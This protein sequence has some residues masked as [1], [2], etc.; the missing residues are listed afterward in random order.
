MTSDEGILEVTTN[1]FG[2]EMIGIK[3][4]AWEKMEAEWTTALTDKQGK[5]ETSS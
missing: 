4:E 5:K 2:H 3:P 1:S